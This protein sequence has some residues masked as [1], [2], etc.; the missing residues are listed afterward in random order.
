MLIFINI[1]ACISACKKPPY[2]LKSGA[3]GFEKAIITNRITNETT[4]KESDDM[5][6]DKNEF[7]E[8]GNLFNFQIY[9]D[10]STEYFYKKDSTCFVLNK[11]LAF[12]VIGENKLQLHFPYRSGY[13]YQIYEVIIILCWQNVY[14]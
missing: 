14:G 9:I 10:E 8:W 12:E 1:T 6:N 4:E 3:Y 7:K 13:D 2:P 5:F 11:G